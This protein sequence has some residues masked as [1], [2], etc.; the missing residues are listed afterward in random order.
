ML[1]MF[2]K[3]MKEVNDPSFVQFCCRINNDEMLFFPDEEKMFR[4]V[5]DYRSKVVIFNLCMFNVKF[6][7]YE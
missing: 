4:Y 1:R 6:Y 2:K 5:E 3:R 7:S